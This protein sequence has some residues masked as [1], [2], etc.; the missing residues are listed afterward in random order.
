MRQ[1]LYHSILF[2]A[3]AL[4]LIL[5]HRILRAHIKICRSQPLTGGQ[6][7]FLLASNIPHLI[8]YGKEMMLSEPSIY[9]VAGW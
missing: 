8:P 5:N 2:Q 1:E 6:A 3:K 4:F 7:D 9:D